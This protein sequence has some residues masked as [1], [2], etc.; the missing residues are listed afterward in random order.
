MF[1]FTAV[2]KITDIKASKTANN[3]LSFNIRCYSSHKNM[4][5]TKKPQK[6][7]FITIAPSNLTILCSNIK[8]LL[9]DLRTSQ[10]VTQY[11]HIHI[12]QVY[13]N[14]VRQTKLIY[15]RITSVINCKRIYR[16]LRV[17]SLRD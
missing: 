17:S 6:S 12:V 11:E 10:L 2:T 3:N 1:F 9:L 4:Q 13:K 7:T 5:S 14:H 8:G 15:I 16:V